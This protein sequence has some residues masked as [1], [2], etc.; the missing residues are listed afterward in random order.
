MQKYHYQSE[1]RVTVPVSMP[2]SQMHTLN[3]LAAE[4]G[5]TR[6][7]LVREALALLTATGPTTRTHLAQEGNA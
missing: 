1:A 3:L 4:R 7:A 5:V 6:S 2:A